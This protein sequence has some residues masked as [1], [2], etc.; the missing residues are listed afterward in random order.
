M[1]S[2]YT[3]AV[4]AYVPDAERDERVNI[5][6]LLFTP[7]GGRARFLT[8]DLRRVLAID[9]DADQGLLLRQADVWTRRV[10][11]LTDG[12]PDAA[13]LRQRLADSTDKIRFPRV[14]VGFAPMASPDQVDA[15]AQWL[16]DDFVAPPKA[17][18]QP[19]HARARTNRETLA[20]GLHQR[21]LAHHPRYEVCREVPITR[22]VGTSPV[23]C[24]FALGVRN[25][26]W[27]LVEV[28]DAVRA[29][30]T[31]DSENVV[32]AVAYKA[33]MA[34]RVLGADA[35]VRVLAAVQLPPHDRVRGL[36]RECLDF[37][38]G[39]ENWFDLGTDLDRFESVLR[40]TAGAT[41]G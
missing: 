19:W 36:A 25:D 41:R 15:L 34:R 4:A 33:E 27:T 24:R 28:D 1:T 31:P 20:G 13:A 23:G 5:G 35:G 2:Q 10:S 37:S 29:G 12:V 21:L 18:F 39:P 14:E 3:Y 6:V 30:R 9:P 7:V 38:Y 32:R 17:P 11:C 26:V 22:L 8:G 16:F 40:R